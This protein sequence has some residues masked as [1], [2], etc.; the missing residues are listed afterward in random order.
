MDLFVRYVYT[1][2][3]YK[4]TMQDVCRVHELQSTE[5]LVGKEL[6]VFDRQVLG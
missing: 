4:V 2:L 1:T 3:S 5:H 6:D